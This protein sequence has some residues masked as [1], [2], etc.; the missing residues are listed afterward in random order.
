MKIPRN[1]TGQNLI[2]ILKNYG[3]STMELSILV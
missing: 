1:I 2:K 3:Y